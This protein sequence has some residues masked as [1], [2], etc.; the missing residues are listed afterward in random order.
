MFNLQAYQEIKSEIPENI[1][2]LAATKTKSIEDIKQAVLAGIRIIGENYVQ[3]A[4]EKHALLKDF[5]KQNNVSF[6]LIGHLQSNKVQEAIKIFD[7]I[8][9]IDSEKLAVKIDKE[10]RRA[11]KTIKVMI[12]INFDEENKSGIKLENLN[13][14][15]QKIKE[16]SNLRL[17]G[18]MAIPPIG[19]EE[20][21]F[22]K[23]NELKKQY[24]FQELSMGMS[25]DY[26]T[27]IKN[28]ST[29]IRLGTILLGN[30]KN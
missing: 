18:L 29:I 21:C 8:Q 6:H 5:F 19:Q 14:L 30:R 27:A 9:T 1:K 7:C 26:L 20:N 13:Q 22:K 15:A 23:M 3:E 17:I 24:N 25:N 12:E 10:C 4:E 16:L 28:G 11:N 2:I